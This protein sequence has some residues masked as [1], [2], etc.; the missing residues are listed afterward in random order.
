MLALAYGIDSRLCLELDGETA[1][2]VCHAP[3]GKPLEDVE[4]AVGRALAEPLEFPPLAQA[5]LPGDKVVLALDSCVPQAG[6]IVAETVQSLVRAGVDPRD[7]VLLRARADVDSN[8]PDPLSA[9]PEALRCVVG[10]RVHD[11]ANRDALCYLAAAADARP[12]YVNRAIHDAEV[13]ISI[14]V[15]RLA[16]SLGY[17][18]V[19]SALFPA[20]SD[21]QSFE[22]YHST[23]AAEEARRNRL[24]RQA[25]EV[26]WLLGLQFTIQ[27][28][29]G[30]GGEILHV[31]AGDLDAVSR[32]G[33]R[34]CEAAWSFSVRERASLV[35]AAIAGDAP[36]QTW[37]NVARA[38]AAAEHVLDDDGAIV[39]CSDL[40][41]PPGPAL[42]C[43]AGADDPGGALRQIARRRLPDALEAVQLARSLARG[44]VYLVSRLDDETV[45]ALGILPLEA[46]GVARLAGRYPSC[47]VLTNAQYAQAH[48]ADET[49]PQGAARG[50]S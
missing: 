22:R 35:L 9:L 38:L 29:P 30:A 5:V 14:G 32:E 45:E 34:L 36:E 21:A 11:P 15:L 12:I 50:K 46:R 31:V 48:P 3:R 33:G 24:W 10:S 6:R 26:G 49:A 4:Q 25:D 40:A 2:T 27:V 8:A 42:Q 7:I 13:V 37:E 17:Y 20:F 39:V 28:V 47:V 1:V 18:G 43:L 19:N 23:Q 16:G 44:K 41:E